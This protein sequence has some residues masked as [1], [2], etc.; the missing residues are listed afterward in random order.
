MKK[1]PLAPLV[2]ISSV[3]LAACGGPRFESDGRALPTPDDPGIYLLAGDELRRIDGS[4]EWEQKTWP[5]RSDLGPDVEFIVF[6]PSIAS[7]PAGEAITLARVA[8]LR[9][10]IERTGQAAP[11]SGSQW[12]VTGL[13]DFTEPMVATPHPELA[14]VVHLRPTDWRLQ[15]G[16]YELALTTGTRRRARVGVLWSSLDK[17]AYSAANCVDRMLAYEARFQSCTDSAVA[18]AQEISTPA[19]LSAPQPAVSAL[20]ITLD[21]PVREHGGLTIRGSIL[22]TSGSPQRV[23]T[24]KG[25]IYDAAGQPTD[26]WLFAAPEESVAPGSESGFTTWRPAPDGAARLNVDFVG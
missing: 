3:A 1:F 22:N 25:T 8:W 15:P 9:S 4:P 5:S 16:L 2:L 13:D 21:K 26:T 17:R 23:P 20:R 7:V 24:L 19:P 11:A 6:D 18:P 14:G 10:E 12:V